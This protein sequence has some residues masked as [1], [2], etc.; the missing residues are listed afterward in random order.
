MYVHSCVHSLSRGRQLEHFRLLGPVNLFAVGTGVHVS[1]SVLI[2]NC[3]GPAGSHGNSVLHVR[4][5]ARPCQTAQ[6]RFLSPAAVCRVPVTLNLHLPLF[7]ILWFPV[8]V[9]RTQSSVPG[10]CASCFSMDWWCRTTNVYSKSLPVFYCFFFVVVVLF[11]FFCH[12]IIGVLYGF[13]I[14]CQ[15]FDLWIFSPILRVVFEGDF[16]DGVLCSIKVP[17]FKYSQ[18]MFFVGGGVFSSCMR[19]IVKS[20]I[21][22][23]SPIFSSKSSVALTLHLIFQ[24]I[25]G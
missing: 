21:M 3:F 12:W 24:P 25:L 23:F 17:D 20:R 9:P 5:T 15:V 2:F 19:T 16:L 11:C 8:S 1:V 10:G 4:G 14:P 22:M 18:Y 13:W 6:L 7:A